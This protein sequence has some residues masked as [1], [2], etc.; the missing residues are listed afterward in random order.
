MPRQPKNEY[1]HLLNSNTSTQK[2]ITFSMIQK[3][4]KN[5]KQDASVTIRNKSQES[6]AKPGK[7][8]FV[9]SQK[10]ISARPNKRGEKGMVQTVL[11]KGNK[12]LHPKVGGVFPKDSIKN[13]LS[14][15]NESSIISDSTT[16]YDHSSQVTQKT[17]KPRAKLKRDQIV[18][19][20]TRQEITSGRIGSGN[21]GKQSKQNEGVYASAYQNMSS[22]SMKKS[23]SLSSKRIEK[24]LI[25]ENEPKNIAIKSF[26]NYATQKNTE[27]AQTFRDRTVIGLCLGKK[28]GQN[29]QV[30]R[31]RGK[32][33]ASPPSHKRKS[34]DTTFFDK[35]K[36]GNK[37]GK[38]V[39]FDSISQ[40]DSMNTTE[41][42]D[43]QITSANRF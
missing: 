30:S 39:E 12:R 13:V 34:S 17:P 20:M 36:L 9:I 3:P 2:N 35:F 32:D 19:G 40:I 15:K 38:H 7:K 29:L 4:C 41:K 16:R 28:R 42:A 22:E 18:L 1:E 10:V 14:L 27:E 8:R 5:F 26:K 11:K 43:P 23:C 6:T 24:Y 25:K 21:A 31:Y 37:K 33:V